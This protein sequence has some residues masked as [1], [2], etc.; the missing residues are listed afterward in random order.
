MA[1]CRDMSV[2]GPWRCK[3]AAATKTISKK[4][5]AG[6]SA[7]LTLSGKG[8]IVSVCAPTG[9]PA[10]CQEGKAPGGGRPVLAERWRALSACQN[11]AA[12]PAPEPH[13]GISRRQTSAHH[14]RA[15]EPIDRL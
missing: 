6:R 2:R 3:S 12:F 7:H 5:W 14:G 4:K 13:D 1:V 11:P 9:K 10:C 15:L 8:G